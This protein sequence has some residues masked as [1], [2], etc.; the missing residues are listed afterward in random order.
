MRKSFRDKVRDALARK[1]IAVVTESKL[2]PGITTVDLVTAE[3]AFQ[4]FWGKN[5]RKSISWAIGGTLYCGTVYIAGHRFSATGN[6][7]DT[8]M[9]RI[10]RKFND[11]VPVYTASGKEIE[12]QV[13][14]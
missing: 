6:T 1:H 3:V 2:S 12:R 9:K 11:T 5:F 13:E 7:K 14:A 10:A 4:H 8:V